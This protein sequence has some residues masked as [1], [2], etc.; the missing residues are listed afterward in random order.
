MPDLE[1]NAWTAL[2]AVLTM[3]LV[4]TLKL[5]LTGRLSGSDGT[6][7]PFLFHPVWLAPLAALVPYVC[8]AYVDGRMSPWPP[9]AF[10]AVQAAHGLWAGVSAGMAVTI[11]DLWLLWT[12]ARALIAFTEPLA[13]IY[14]PIPRAMHKYYHLV[15][16]V[17]GAFVIYKAATAAGG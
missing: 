12:T 3:T 5:S 13:P 15:N 1:L 17:V 16:L 8:G 7:P 14:D 10:A 4:V 9:A 6:K 2:A 11:I